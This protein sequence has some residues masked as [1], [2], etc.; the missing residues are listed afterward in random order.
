M[1]EERSSSSLTGVWRF[2]SVFD[3]VG[4]GSVVARSLRSGLSDGAGNSNGLYPF[5]PI[6]IRL[7]PF[8]L[9]KGAGVPFRLIFLGCK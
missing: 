4:V 1:N 7:I 8:R 6:P 3:T 9:T 5:R 2:D